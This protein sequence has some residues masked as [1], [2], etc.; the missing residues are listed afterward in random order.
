MPAGTP[1]IFASATPAQ[2]LILFQGSRYSVCFLRS[3][4]LEWAHLLQTVF[5][6]DFAYWKFTNN[7]PNNLE[8]KADQRVP[9]YKK[10]KKIKK[11]GKK[12]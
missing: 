8:M 9:H 4:V 3:S 10:N 6:D 5:M 1:Q 7:Y 12:D 11:Q 2:I